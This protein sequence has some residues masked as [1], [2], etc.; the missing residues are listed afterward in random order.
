MIE[1]DGKETLDPD[2]KPPTV[3]TKEDFLTAVRE[4]GLVGLGGAGFPAHVKL[5]VPKDKN[6][7]TLIINCAECE[8]YITADYREVLEN[9][10]AILSGIYAVRE[11]L[12][13]ERA[14]IGIE[15]NKP[16]AIKILSEIADNEKYDPED[17]VTV[18]SLKSSYPQGAEKVLIKALTNREVPE[19]KLPSDV[20]CVVMNVA[21]V[22]FLSDYLKTGIPLVKKRVTVDGSAVKNPQ[23]VIVPL[24]TRISDLMEFCGGFK[25]EPFK[26]LMGGPMM[27]IALVDDSLPVLKQN[28]AILAFGRKEAKL[29]EETAC[30]RC[31][32]CVSACPMNLMPTKIC[33]A[34]KKGDAEEMEKFHIMNCMECGCCAFSCP[35]KRHIVQTIK[36]GKAQLRAELQ[37]KKEGNK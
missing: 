10:W 18:V 14:I 37:K 11:I 29:A 2:I 34:V 35:A 15:N 4:S 27:G 24:G 25:E 7:D 5:N 33:D 22:A 20:G 36:V 31:G 8:P 28:N 23:N 12:G 32:R 17:L 30:I 6:I 16:D 13:I 1:S 9:S 19:G 21:S 3:E 26:M